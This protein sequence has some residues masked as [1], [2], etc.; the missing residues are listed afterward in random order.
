MAGWVYKRGVQVSVL[1]SKVAS[2]LFKLLLQ[3]G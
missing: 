2:A 3:K 1:R